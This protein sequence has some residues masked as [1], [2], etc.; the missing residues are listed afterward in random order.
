MKS[1]LALAGKDLR[2]L[3]RV[4]SGLFFTFVWP[5]IV[6]V[7]FGFVFSGQSSS[8]RTLRVVV[9]D[10]DNSERVARIRLDARVVRRLHGRSLDACGRRDHGSAG[11]A[12][13]VRRAEAGIWCR[14]GAD[15]LRRAAADRDRHRPGAAGRG[16]DDRGAADQ[17]CDGGH[18]EAVQR[19]ARLAQDGRLG[20][21]GAGNRRQYVG[22]RAALA[23]PGR[24]RH[25]PRHAGGRRPQS[26][27]RRA[28]SRS[29]SRSP[30]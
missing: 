11:A 19:S 9:V 21:G 14:V 22:D 26:G 5:V 12:G 16:V 6:A 13:G 2:L 29:R 17:A 20:A 15:V 23:I 25:V 4:K 27:R 24:A 28:G 3:V 30:P 1:I 8:S 10:E 18:A 7:L